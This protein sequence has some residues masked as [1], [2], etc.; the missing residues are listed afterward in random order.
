MIVLLKT[1]YQNKPGCSCHPIKIISG[2]YANQR[3]LK[4]IKGLFAKLF[5]HIIYI[6][7]IYYI[8]IIYY[9]LFVLY[10]IYKLYIYVYSK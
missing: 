3:I 2:Q 9:Y 4:W 6:C 8:S 1:K 5:M 7:Y 10:I